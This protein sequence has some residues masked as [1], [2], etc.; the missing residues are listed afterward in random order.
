MGA[1]PDQGASTVMMYMYVMFS[2]QYSIDSDIPQ[3][4]RLLNI[5]DEKSTK[6]LP[7]SVAPVSVVT[8]D[9]PPTV[10]KPPSI[11]PKTEH[12][13]IPAVPPGLGLDNV[14]MSAIR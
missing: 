11:V 9:S 5:L 4:Q 6:S 7:A 8:A 3:M 2:K 12:K 10:P 13:L 1:A 14:S